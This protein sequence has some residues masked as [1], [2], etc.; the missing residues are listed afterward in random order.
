MANSKQLKALLKA[1]VDG[2]NDHFF[3][4]A[5]QVA[6]SEAKRGQGKLAE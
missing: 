1:H 5:M 6:A 2:D 3:S 4:V